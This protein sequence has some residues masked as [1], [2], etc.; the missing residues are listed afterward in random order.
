MDWILGLDLGTTHCKAVAVGP[1]GQIGATAEAAYPLRTE[2]PGA[3][4]QAPDTVWEG[5]GRVLRDVAGQ[6][7]QGDTLA[8]LSLCG[9]MHSLLAVTRQG[10][11]LGKAVTWAD[12]RAEVSAAT[13][14]KSGDLYALYARTG[15]PIQPVYHPIKLRWWRQTHPELAKQAELYVS[16][17]DWVAYRL[18]GRW[19]ADWSVASASGL[20]DIHRMAWDDQA[21]AL[22]GISLQ[23]LPE[24]VPPAVVIGTCCPRQLP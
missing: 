2:Q 17:K 15:C 1:E 5:V 21:V 12:L 18:T 7:G 24:L 19:T 6:I 3:A 10:I 13:V 16:I 23:Q 20:M 11:P 22:A 4:E 8:G 9:A 14:Q